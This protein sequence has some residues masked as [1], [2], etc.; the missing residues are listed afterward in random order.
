M[1]DVWPF[2]GKRLADGSI[3]YTYDLTALKASSGFADA[4]EANGEEK[5]KAFLAGLPKRVTVKVPPNTAVTL[6][7]GQ[8][9]ENAPLTTSF[10]AT[11][12]G[13]L[14]TDNPLGKKQGARL[15]AP[16]DPRTPR[17]LV[18][19]E[20]PLWLA[21]QVEDAA[22]AAVEVDTE[23]MRRELWTKVA[24]RALARAKSSAGDTREGAFALAA[25]VFAASSC[26][27]VSRLPAAVKNDVELKQ[28]VEAEL[29]K[30]AADGDSLVAPAPWSWSAE[31]SCAWFR[32]RMVSQ[33]FEKSRAGTAAVLV[34]W[35]LL[36]TDAKLRA[37]WER[38]R[39]RRDRFLGSTADEGALV[40]RAAAK[41]DLGRA[42]DGMNEFLEALPLTGRTPPPLLAWPATP[43]STFRSELAGAERTTAMDELSAAVADK[44]VNPTGASWPVLREQ[45][46]A[47]LLTDTSRAL[48]I[49]AAWRDRRAGA[50]AA[51]QG[52]HRD[53]RRGGLDA[54]DEVLDR[55]QL[56]IRLNAPPLL[57]VEPTAGA[58]EHQARAL[59]A[60]IAA[61]KAENLAGL[62]GL[63]ADG[64]RSG[65][66]VVREAERLI[67]IL[68]GLA[69]LSTVESTAV[70]PKAVAAARRFLA[71][72]RAE[73]GLGRDVRATFASE[74]AAGP[75]RAHAALVG[76]SRRELRVGF[77]SP[78]PKAAVD[79]DGQ[80]FVV[81]TAV[82]QRYLVPVLVTIG[83]VAPRAVKA[84][85]RA[86]LKALVDGSGRSLE[87]LEGA[88]Q[89]ILHPAS[90]PGVN[91]SQE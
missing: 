38:V 33:P 90:A 79:G 23:W 45:A 69:K 13:P 44:R 84:A 16:L 26:G 19:V 3:E 56:R 40:W 63:G 76:V 85:D 22:L 35:E 86:A 58:F 64:R 9:L 5:V 48:Q 12:E 30:L 51:L 46:L 88:L 66:T 4:K 29:V 74:W 20:Q 11:P 27:E 25:R 87:K 39:Q 65:D 52:S 43:F 36:E 47:P 34:F 71:G 77:A 59:E 37:L 75:E 62:R 15:L 31:L 7:G 68:E 70:D 60:L 53:A 67:P 72:W 73:P 78:Q 91:G 50:F 17:L 2:Q 21:R 81:N 83:A 42:L 6:S 80:G 41:G 57:E 54:D 18:G 14:A 10:A 55:T 82:E 1:A 28:L 24:E 8:G 61:L 32:A 89:G 49:D